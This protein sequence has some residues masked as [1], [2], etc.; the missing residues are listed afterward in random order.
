MGDPPSC[1]G[2]CHSR[3]QES[4]VTVTIF[5]GASGGDGTSNG[6]LRTTGLSISKNSLVP[7]LL[8]VA[9]RKKMSLPSTRF[10]SVVLQESVNVFSA[11]LQ[12]TFK[13]SRFSIMYPV[14]AEPPSSSGGPHSKATESLDKTFAVNGRVGVPGGPFCLCGT[15]ES[16]SNG[17]LAPTLLKAVTLN[18]T[19]RSSVRSLTLILVTSASVMVTS[20]QTSC[21]ELTSTLYA[22]IGAPPLSRGGNHS[23]I[24]LLAPTSLKRIGPTGLSG[25]PGSFTGTTASASSA[26]GPNPSS[27]S[28][29]TRKKYSAPSRS[30][31]T[32]RDVTSPLVVP[33][34]IQDPQRLSRRSIRYD[35]I[36][37][38]PVSEGTFH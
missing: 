1:F 36:G 22:V 11:R 23:M 9:T 20:V 17:L 26:L 14:M 21:F 28:A 10:F 32:F 3:S 4:C 38:P 13:A 30:C 29:D 35:R 8:T 15:T 27:F 34:L 2:G 33:A 6:D 5:R 12:D 24:R 19:L 25:A 37:R 18:Q 16:E 7:S 31:S